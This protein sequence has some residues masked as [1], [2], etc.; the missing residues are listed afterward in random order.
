MGFDHCVHIFL[1]PCSSPHSSIKL[2]VLKLRDQM[3]FIFTLDDKPSDSGNKTSKLSM[4]NF[5]AILWEQCWLCLSS[6][7]KEGVYFSCRHPS[8]PLGMTNLYLCPY[9]DSVNFH[10]TMLDSDL[11]QCQLHNVLMH[12]VKC[13]MQ[14]KLTW[15]YK[16]Q[17]SHLDERKFHTG[18]HWSL[19][20]E[21]WLFIPLWS[22]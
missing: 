17:S 20:N 15:W 7:K 6:L 2:L 4:G 5:N 14:L 10:Y 1:P 16:H 13:A 12:H 3:V 8:L 19:Q 22:H 21:V 9:S 18:S 11:S